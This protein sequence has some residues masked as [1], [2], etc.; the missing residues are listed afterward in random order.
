M[1]LAMSSRNH[2]RWTRATLLDRGGVALV[3]AFGVGIALS[4]APPARG[5]A[6]GPFAALYGNWSGNGQIKKSNGGR[7][8]I[9]CN[10][11]YSA[12]G[13]SNLQLHLNCASDSYKFNLSSN[14]TNNGDMLSGT[15]SEASRGVM[16]TIHGSSG[17]GGRQIK[18][19]AQAAAFSA[20]LTLTTRGNHQSVVILSPGTEVPEVDIAL[21]RR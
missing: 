7:E 13:A 16:G 2:N 14:V 6:E 10:A 19:T 15:W 21:D 12:A 3:A 8:R 1:R 20:D 11:T 17:D 18:A 4:T 9:K 5:A